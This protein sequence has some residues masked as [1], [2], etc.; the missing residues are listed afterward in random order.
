MS[1]IMKI[2]LKNIRIDEKYEENSKVNK[3]GF[4]SK[5]GARGANMLIEQLGSKV[6]RFIDTVRSSNAS[7]T[8]KLMQI[9]QDIVISQK[10]LRLIGLP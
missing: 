9:P 3:F 4:R 2:I 6:Y 5:H 1:H 10:I 8:K 7:N